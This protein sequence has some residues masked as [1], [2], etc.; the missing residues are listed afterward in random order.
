MV[1]TRRKA[2]PVVKREAL[3]DSR[4]PA[5]TVSIVFL[6]ISMVFTLHV[7]PSYS[8]TIER[9]IHPD[10]RQIA[11]T[12]DDLPSPY[13][14]M[15]TIVYVRDNLIPRIVRDSIPAVGFVN[16]YKLYVRGE[17]DERVAILE[18][19]LNAGIELGNHTFSHIRIDD[20]TVE[21]YTSDVIRGETVTAWLMRRSGKKLR[22]FRHPQ[23]RTGPTPDFKASVDEFLHSRGYTVA[24]VTMDNDEYV[25]A[26]VYHMAKCNGDSLVMS[27]IASAYLTYMSGIVDHFEEI[28]MEFL[29]RNI[30]HILLLHANELNAD[31]FGELIGMLRKKSYSF[32]TLEKAL[33]DPAYS[34]PEACSTRGISWLYRW[35]IAE[36]RTSPEQPRPSATVMELFNSYYR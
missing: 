25:F 6:C 27:R 10:N 30:N 1:G 2:L 33:S 24:P 7:I 20:A 4:N 12:I 32:I 15:E 31:H 5:T 26:A 36:G 34:L 29:G 19:W 16:E 11:I 14:D 13:D 22:F 21:A 9:D 17:I 23:L 3:G 8:D 28:S 18:Q 35:M